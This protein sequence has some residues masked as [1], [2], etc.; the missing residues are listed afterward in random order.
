MDESRP[1]RRR[2]RNDCPIRGPL[3]DDH[4]RLGCRRKHVPGRGSVPHRPLWGP[5]RLEYILS[6][7][8]SGC[9]FCAAA[10][11]GEEHAKWV[12][13]RGDHCFTILNT[14]PYAPGHLMVARMRHV[15]ELEELS[16]RE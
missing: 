13:D 1:V 14:F 8:G 10:N 4:E 16:D 2:A 7:K 3:V 15:A 6:A 5:W 12:V 11:G 9:I